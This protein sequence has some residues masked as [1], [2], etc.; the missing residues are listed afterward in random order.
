MK[1]LL[2]GMQEGQDYTGFGLYTNIAGLVTATDFEHFEQAQYRINNNLEHLL[3]LIIP[4][5][6]PFKISFVGLPWQSSG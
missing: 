1:Y 5:K 2:W 6:L 3:I 4:S